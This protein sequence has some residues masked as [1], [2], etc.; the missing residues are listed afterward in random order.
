MNCPV[1]G[2]M[3]TG[4]APHCESIKIQMECGSCGHYEN[5]YYTREEMMVNQLTAATGASLKDCG[6]V[7]ETTGD[8]LERAE[9]FLGETQDL[10][11]AAK[12]AY[13][14]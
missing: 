14:S 8:N 12:I 10:S 1:C 3:M 9:S 13:A 2:K 4:G 11:G 6:R 7:L 5:E